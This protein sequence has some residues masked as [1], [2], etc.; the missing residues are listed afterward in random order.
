MHVDKGTV[1]RNL[2]WRF[3][4]RSGAQGVSLIVSIVLARLL[5]PEVYGTVALVTVITNILQVFVDSGLGNALIQKKGADDLDFSTVFYCNFAICVLLYIGMYIAAPWIASFYKMDELTAL[6]RVISLTLVISGL[7]NIQQ[8]YISRNLLFKRFF[9]ATIGGTIFSAVLG[10]TMAY[11]GFGCWA[12]VAQQLSNTAIDTLILWNS[13]KWRP[14]LLFSWK[15]FCALFSY[16]WKLLIS[17][18]LDVGYN[19][20]S[21][22]LIGKVYTAADLAFYNKGS[23]FPSLIVTN[24]NSSINSVLLPTISKEQDDRERV[25]K[26]TRKSIRLSCFVMMPM[27]TGLAMI[28]EPLVALLLTEKWLFCVPYLRIFCVIYAFWP[29]HTANLN[30]INAVGRSDIFLKLEIIKKVL[31]IT[32]TLISLPFGV[33]AIALGSLATSPIGAIVNAFPNQKLLNYSIKE[34]CLDLLPFVGISAIMG[35]SIWPLQYLALPELAVVLLQ[36]LLG[37]MIYVICSALFKI[38]CYFETLAI[39]KQF[40]CHRNKYA[41]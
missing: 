25:K 9:F 37:M 17:S 22:L 5:T 19:N 29:I 7:K 23:Q 8:A 33:L 4:E 26:M 27:M 3:A 31:G 13:V 14:K 12:I 24:I 28:A 21:S 34:Q 18:L 41:K 10:I 38:D 15:R 39:I 40:F 16:G 32:V 36:I 35:A 11:L 1:I 30:A 6:V 2:I 20:L